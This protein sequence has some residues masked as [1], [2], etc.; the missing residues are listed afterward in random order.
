MATHSSVLAWR[1]PGTGEPGGHLSMG[2][3]RVGHDWS[4]LAE[5]AFPFFRGGKLR[6]REIKWLAIAHRTS[7]G[8]GFYGHQDLIAGSL[9]SCSLQ[10]SCLE[11]NQEGP[12]SK[13]KNCTLFWR[14]LLREE[15]SGWG[16]D[17]RKSPWWSWFGRRGPGG[18]RGQMRGCWHESGK[19]NLIHSDGTRTDT[20]WVEQS[21]LGEWWMRMIVERVEQGSRRGVL[22][23][24]ASPGSMP[25]Q[26][27][28]WSL[29]PS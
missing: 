12:H 5:A 18:K 17:S 11:S 1:I 23:S 21:R 7:E 16:W 27:W 3:H 14:F 13:Q 29:C 10:T 9:D 2:S 24:P 6:H 28:M 25:T 19:H 15:T 26:P 22:W 8:Q 4:D 20:R